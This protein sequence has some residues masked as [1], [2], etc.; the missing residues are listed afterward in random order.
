[1]TVLERLM[2]PTQIMNDIHK[3]IV[4][5]L[6]ENFPTTVTPDYFSIARFDEQRPLLSHD[7]VSRGEAALQFVDMLRRTGLAEAHVFEERDRSFSWDV[8]LT[9]EGYVALKHGLQ[10]KAG[11]SVRDVCAAAIAKKTA[12]VA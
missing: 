8:R 12:G 10:D 5:L 4:D 6:I 9:P 7:D 2:E 1:M 11:A 3:A